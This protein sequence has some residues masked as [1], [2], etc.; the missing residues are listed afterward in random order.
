M[1]SLQNT[2]G[3][4]EKIRGPRMSPVS[5]RSPYESTS[6]VAVCGSRVVVTP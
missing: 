4:V 1:S 2:P 3:P 5:T 6:V